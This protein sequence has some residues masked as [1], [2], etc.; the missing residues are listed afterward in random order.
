MSE[1]RL[2]SLTKHNELERGGWFPDALMF[3][4]SRGART[5]EAF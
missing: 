1:E 2:G 5:S 3:L 4:L